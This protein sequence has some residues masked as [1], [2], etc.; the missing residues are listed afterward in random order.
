VCC[1]D[2]RSCCPQDYPVCDTRRG[3]CLKVCINNLLSILIIS[4]WS[5]V[6]QTGW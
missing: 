3:Q 5:D 2:K 6:K 4:R 1:K